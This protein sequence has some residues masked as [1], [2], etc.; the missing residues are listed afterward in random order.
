MV[1]INP[2]ALSVLQQTIAA[3]RVWLFLDYDGTLIDFERT[4]D[5]IR[6]DPDLADLLTGLTMRR[7][8]RI[9]VVSGRRLAD[10]R[11]L[12]PIKDIWLAGTYGAEWLTPSGALINR[13][14]KDKIRPVLDTIKIEWEK[15][16]A[17]S[18]GFYLEDKG[19]SLAL[20]ARYAKKSAADAKLTVARQLIEQFYNP[21]LLC[22]LGG[23]KF[24][25]VAPLIANKSLA[26]KYI[27]ETNPWPYTTLIYIGD[28]DKDEVAFQTIA[29]LGGIGIVVSKKN[30]QHTQ[31][32]CRLES[33]RQVREWLNSLLDTTTIGGDN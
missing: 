21:N 19:L 31:A 26:V 25:E 2:V 11:T 10:L 17:E 27:L 30:K 22:I 4:P 12:L 16:I 23:N 33:P 14:E 6:P 5:I 3:E 20:H 1:G 29:N 7:G 28:D 24:L 8:L 32:S 13:L 9:A 15:V 18:T